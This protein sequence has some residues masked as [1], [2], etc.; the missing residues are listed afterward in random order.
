MNLRLLLL[1]VQT[2]FGL[3]IVDEVAIYQFHVNRVSEEKN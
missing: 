2:D 3:N 1:Q